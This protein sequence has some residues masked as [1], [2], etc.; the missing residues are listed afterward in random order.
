VTHEIRLTRPAR[1]AL[2][3]T[4]PEKIVHAVVEFMQGPLAE[5]PQ[6]VSKA[7]EAPLD[8]LRSARR[9]PY[10]IVLSVD[11]Q[12]MVVLIRQIAHRDDV[13]RPPTEPDWPCS[14]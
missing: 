5:N 7:L 10:R 12:N 1:R 6:R 4:L 14:T 13:Y 2:A 3:E 9:G 11:D 8:G